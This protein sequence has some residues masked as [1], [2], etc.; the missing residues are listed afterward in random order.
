[1]VTKRPRIL[2]QPVRTAE[3]AELR[4]YASAAVE[5]RQS[6]GRKRAIAGAARELGLSPRRVIGLLRGEVSRVWADELLGA[7]AWYRAHVERQARLLEQEAA[8]H[9]AL[10]DEWEAG[11][12]RD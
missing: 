7:R 10:L 6:E 8:V 2:E 4:G 12:P 5:A 9:R 3:A 1:M 11:C